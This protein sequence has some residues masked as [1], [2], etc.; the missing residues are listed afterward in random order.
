[1]LSD[2]FYL[3]HINDWAE[4]LEQNLTDAAVS[5]NLVKMMITVKAP[6][7]PMFCFCSISVP[8][9]TSGSVALSASVS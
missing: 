1:L 9:G 5:V 8:I 7:F 6:P 4:I 3:L 2:D